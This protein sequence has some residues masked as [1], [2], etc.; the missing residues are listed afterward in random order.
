MPPAAIGDLRQALRLAVKAVIG[1][2][3][4]AE[5]DTKINAGPH[6]RE[7]KYPDPCCFSEDMAMATEPLVGRAVEGVDR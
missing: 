1:G 4:E 6:E 7:G 5:I 3:A 2:L